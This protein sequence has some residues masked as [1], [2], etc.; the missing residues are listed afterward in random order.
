MA[1]AVAAG[2]AEGGTL[3]EYTET[4]PDTVR[5]CRMMVVFH[6]LHDVPSSL[7]EENLAAGSGSDT[8]GEGPGGR[9]EDEEERRRRRRRKRRKERRRRRSGGGAGRRRDTDSDTSKVGRLE[10]ALLA[11]S[12]PANNGD[13]GGGRGGEGT[14]ASTKASPGAEQKLQSE[15][16]TEGAHHGDVDD[17]KADG[18]NDDDEAEDADD[19]YG[20]SDFEDDFEDDDDGDGDGD[21]DGATGGDRDGNLAELAEAKLAASGDALSPTARSHASSGSASR[22]PSPSRRSRSRSRSRSPPSR[23]YSR[24]MSSDSDSQDSMGSRDRPSSSDT[25]SS[26]YSS[27]CSGGGSGGREGR[28]GHTRGKRYGRHGRQGTSSSRGRRGLPGKWQRGEEPV[29]RSF[30][31]EYT[32]LGHTVTLPLNVTREKL[33]MNKNEGLVFPLRRLKI[34]SFFIPP[35]EHTASTA[36]AGAAAGAARATGAA[37]AEAAT[38]AVQ[39]ERD[40]IFK[41]SPKKGDG[42]GGVTLKGIN[43]YLD[44][45]K[46]LTISFM[47]ACPRQSRGGSGAAKASMGERSGGKGRKRSS[48][49]EVPNMPRFQATK[50]G[51]SRKLGEAKIPLSHFRESLMISRHD[52]FAPLGLDLGACSLRAT[53]CLDRSPHLTQT[54]ALMAGGAPLCPWQGLY[55][56]PDSFFPHLALPKEW[57]SILAPPNTGPFALKDV[58]AEVQKA[59]DQR[60]DYARQLVPAIIKRMARGLL[61]QGWSKWFTSTG[62]AVFRMKLRIAAKLELTSGAPPVWCLTVQVQSAHNLRSLDPDSAWY[63]SYDAF[64]ND[65]RTPDVHHT[66]RDA[67]G[68]SCVP[69]NHTRKFYVRCPL[70]SLQRHLAAHPALKVSVCL[71][72]PNLRGRYHCSLRRAFEAAD[73]TMGA[74]AGCMPV[75]N[76]LHTLETIPEVAQALLPSGTVQKQSSSSAAALSLLSPSAI[77]E[78]EDEDDEEGEEDGEDDENQFQA[79]LRILH[80]L[81]SERHAAIIHDAVQVHIRRLRKQRKHEGVRAARI[82][83]REATKTREAREAREARGRVRSSSP[84]GGRGGAG[85]GAGPAASPAS[86]EVEG[87]TKNSTKKL[88]VS[89]SAVHESVTSTEF[90]HIGL[91]AIR[92]WVLFASAMRLSANDK[93]DGGNSSDPMRGGAHTGGIHVLQ[94]G[95]GSIHQLGGVVDEEDDGGEDGDGGGSGVAAATDMDGSTTDADTESDDDTDHNEPVSGGAAAASIL[96]EVLEGSVDGSPAMHRTPTHQAGRGVAVGGV[97]FPVSSAPQTRRGRRMSRLTSPLKGRSGGLSTEVTRQRQDFA[98]GFEAAELYLK[99]ARVP[100]RTLL[101]VLE[102]RHSHSLTP[103][104]ACPHDVLGDVGGTFAPSANIERLRFANAVHAING[105]DAT[106]SRGP[107]Y[108]ITWQEFL[109]RCL[110]TS[111]AGG[112]AQTSIQM[113]PI[114]KARARMTQMQL[115]QQETGLQSWE[116]LKEATGG[117]SHVGQSPSG[118]SR[119]TSF[120]GFASG[121]GGGGGGK[122][123]G[124]SMAKDF[125]HV[126]RDA[127]DMGEGEAQCACSVDMNTLCTSSTID[128]TWQNENEEGHM[129]HMYVC[130]FVYGCVYVCVHCCSVRELPNARRHNRRSFLCLPLSLTLFHRIAFDLQGPTTSNENRRGEALSPPLWAARGRVSSKRVSPTSGSSTRRTSPSPSTWSASPPR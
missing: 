77:I 85:T 21:K 17:G 88:F 18:A 87:Q 69:F 93:G 39:Y 37:G 52:A 103:S 11:N 9:E 44:H 74:D 42:A 96:G 71:R 13:E 112:G 66:R 65:V 91:R 119:P 92:L 50:S 43:R 12:T 58:E 127:T 10:V 128:G 107:N 53:V 95:R 116:V 60:L 97:S 118:M 64:G 38:G 47:E 8:D 23:A 1:A 130:V 78:E 49:R 20:D 40:P 41:G 36:A 70:A 75:N 3:A 31:L 113:T 27:S 63:V 123:G 126:L 84:V 83:E 81:S 111:K 54:S 28:R 86:A 109:E 34:F 51:G 129:W 72:K 45:Q 76:L 19:D 99:T 94:G 108:S 101:E 61:W 7:L 26:S 29:Q 30:Y 79:S 117:A 106:T 124:G 25:D 73:R 122:G 22:S 125:M 16:K 62:M 55:M 14:V 2:V 68:G 59:R 114:Q 100:A 80:Q 24:S 6:E 98:R 120:A 35:P 104:A 15:E 115:K 5:L 82:K 32:L 105:G 33:V 102:A 57:I 121:S 90:Q 46:V 48:S 56:P 4:L 110:S 67:L 89:V